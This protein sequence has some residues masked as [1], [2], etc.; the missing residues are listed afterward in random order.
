[1][2]QIVVSEDGERVDRFLAQRRTDL[3]RSQIQRLIADGVVTANGQ[4]VRSS[5]HVRAGD[6]LSL[7]VPPPP[8][9]V[10]Q[11]EA[12]PL[13]VVYEDADVLIIDKPAGLV[14]HPAPGHASGTVVNAVLAHSP[15]MA[16]M[17]AD[18]E[19]PGIVHRLDK[20]TSGLLVIA[21][22]AQALRF[23]SSQFKE[24][25]THKT[26]L[27]LVYGHLS[28]AHGEIVA[29]LGRDQRYRQRMAV[30]AGGREARTGYSVQQYLADYT[31]VEVTLYTGR[32]HQIRVHFASIGHAVA[33]DHIYGPQ[34]TPAGLGL[35]RQ[36]LHAAGLRL[37]L[38]SGEEREFSSPLPA[39]L[40][41]VLDHLQ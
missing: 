37:R 28:P 26:Y 33:G 2:E 34:H 25:T 7:S 38:L 29:P 41:A 27:A 39:D 21:K 20:D 40:R 30:V 19:R 18:A 11:P 14:V 8:P 36:F 4:A 5:Y 15:E 23:L 12:I 10:A 13:A 16:S 31:L 17:G 32:T 24:R 6:V 9:A 3:S 22:N 35:S 1:M